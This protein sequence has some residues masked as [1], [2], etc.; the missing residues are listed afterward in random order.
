M[1]KQSNDQSGFWLVIAAASIWG[2]IGIATQAIYNADSA[3]SPLFINFARMVIAAPALTFACWRV[4]GRDMFKL[5]RRDLLI[6]LLNGIFMAASQACYFVAIRYTGVTI[7]TL[8]SVCVS[9]LLVTGISVLLKLE[10]PSV[11]AL[12][13]V[14]CALVGSVLLV[15]LNTPAGAQDNLLLG[16]V[17]SIV[18]ALTYAATIFWGRF[19]A[20]SY[21]PLQVMTFTFGS[22]ALALIP[23]NLLSG[24]IAIHTGEGWLYALYLG[25]VP[26]ALAYWMFQ[27]GLRSV[28]PTTASVSTL[29]EPTVAALL[30]WA[31]FGEMLPGTGVIGAGLL[32]LSIFL[33][34]TRGRKRQAILAAE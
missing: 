19:L 20:G 1:L 30:A 26:T 5:P 27:K 9:P 21:H 6:M 2:T 32:I 31:L 25:L 4:V 14:A 17:L 16:A 10:R 15:G 24:A 3:T 8:L 23:I 22:G 11:R 13:A 28:T 7:A 18:A 29:L 33:L 12:I 34:S